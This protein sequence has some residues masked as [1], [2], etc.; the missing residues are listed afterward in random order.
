MCVCTCCPQS[1]WPHT[2]FG[3]PWRSPAPGQGRCPN[4]PSGAATRRALCGLLASRPSRKRP[5]GSA[6]AGQ[7]GSKVRV[8]WTVRAA[9]MMGG[10]ADA[11]RLNWRA[12]ANSDEPCMAPLQRTPLMRRMPSFVRSP[13]S[14]WLPRMSTPRPWWVRTVGPWE[15][16]R[17][18]C[19]RLHSDSCR[20]HAHTPRCCGHGARRSALL[21][22]PRPQ[23]TWPPKRCVLRVQPG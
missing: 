9:M 5:R 2:H 15:A 13:S 4:S 23:M 3:R 6:W 1:S 20:L 22:L 8:E 7:Q 14:C 19:L 12:T 18:C 17:G 21:P 11:A 10:C 16:Q